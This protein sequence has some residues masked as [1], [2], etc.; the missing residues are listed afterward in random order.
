MGNQS[1]PQHP[2]ASQGTLSS[3]RQPNVANLVSGISGVNTGMQRNLAGAQDAPDITQLIRGVGQN[4]FMQRQVFGQAPWLWSQQRLEPQG[5]LSST[6]AS[7]MGG[8][9]K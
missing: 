9:T 5:N 6:G 3:L 2:A 8:N 4:N 7:S 1:T